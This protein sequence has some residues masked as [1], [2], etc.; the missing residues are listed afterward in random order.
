MSTNFS[1]PM[2]NDSFVQ[3]S[4]K[5]GQGFTRYFVNNHTNHAHT[6]TFCYQ[7]PTIM[8]LHAN[9]KHA[10]NVTNVKNLILLI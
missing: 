7:Q 5:F 3:V 2:S 9:Q 1:S 8:K 10:V 4:F 6:H